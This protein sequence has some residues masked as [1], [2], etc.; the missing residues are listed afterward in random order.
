[1]HLE[2]RVFSQET[3]HVQLWESPA[4]V[5]HVLLLSQTATMSASGELTMTD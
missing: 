4:R 3:A 5:N 1:M 2:K